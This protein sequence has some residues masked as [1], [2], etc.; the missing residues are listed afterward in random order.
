MSELLFYLPII[1]GGVCIETANSFRVVDGSVASI[2]ARESRQIGRPLASVGSQAA[3]QQTRSAK[4]SPLIPIFVFSLAMPMLFQIGPTRLSPYRLVL[5]VTF[6]PCLIAWL[7]GSVGRI[8]LPDIL[9]FL[10]AVWGAVV[11][12]GQHGIDTGVQSAGIFVIETFGTFLF[13]RKYIRDVV[14]FRRMVSSLVLMVIFL[15]PF[16]IY[17][18]FVGSPILIELLGK[19][20]SVYNVIGSEMRL[21]LRRAQG[22]FEYSILFGVVCSSAFALSFYVNGVMARRG[23]WLSTGL[24]AMAVLSSLSSG[25]LLSLVVQA[26][27]IGWDR[28]TASVARRWGILA[29]IVAI[30]YIVV[31]FTSNRTPFDV[32]ISYLTFNADTSYMRVHIWHYGTESVVRHP[33]FGLGLTEWD[34]PPWMGGS[35]DN[36]WL[37]TAVRYGIP[38]FLLVAGGF[39]SVCL[40]LGRLKNVS[41]HVAQCRKGLIV[42]L[43]GLAFA[44]C[45]VHVWDA[46]YVLIMFLLGSGMWMFD[47][48]N[49]SASAS[50]AAQGARSRW[51]NRSNQ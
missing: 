29:A 43:C 1:G 49:G 19:V 38:G 30:A 28:I 40:G 36:F 15:L 24:V 8:R 23:E 2:A 6:L 13:A 25:P 37:V 35:I 26:L 48:R 4:V 21:G 18:N 11:L 42:T 16:A 9:I 44:I 20:F 45:T 31:S 33:I 34:H 39:L 46:P 32:F 51:A 5:V 12:I 17:E 3:A 41:F 22:T 14:A 50:F 7:S 27:L 47:P 10:T